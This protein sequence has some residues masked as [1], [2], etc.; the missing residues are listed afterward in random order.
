LEAQKDAQ[1][2]INI[3]FENLKGVDFFKLLKRLQNP[4][5]VDGNDKNDME[6]M[7]AHGIT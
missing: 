4:R 3:T 1:I 6:D 5:M 2:E 7:G